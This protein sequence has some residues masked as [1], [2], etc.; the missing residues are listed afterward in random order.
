MGGL[1]FCVVGG[2]GFVKEDVIVIV[3]CVDNS[4]GVVLDVVV[5]YVVGEVVLVFGNF[6]VVLELFLYGDEEFFVC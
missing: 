3:F 4:W 5:V 6:G 2:D 1:F